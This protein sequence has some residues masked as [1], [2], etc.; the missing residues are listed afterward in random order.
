MSYRSSAKH[1]EARD[2]STS[3]SDWT[4][5]NSRQRYYQAR[6]DKKGKWEYHWDQP[7]ETPRTE[8]TTSSSGS[9]S[10]FQSPSPDASDS[11]GSGYGGTQTIQNASR[12]YASNSSREPSA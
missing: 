11:P 4:W 6:Q 1:Q 5:D 7:A 8:Y 10:K 9:K 12:G 2:L 3:W